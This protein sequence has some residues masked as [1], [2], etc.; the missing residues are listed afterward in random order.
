MKKEQLKYLR[1]KYDKKYRV[2]TQINV[3]STKEF[4][5]EF[6]NFCKENHRSMSDYIRELILFDY[7]RIQENKYPERYE[8]IKK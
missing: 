3:E 8:K 2:E 6:K 5:A 4:K 1:G 7:I